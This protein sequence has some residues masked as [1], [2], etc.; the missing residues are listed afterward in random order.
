[1]VVIFYAIDLADKSVTSLTANLVVKPD[2][3]VSPDGAWLAFSATPTDADAAEAA[4]IYLA[5][6]D[7][8]WRPLVTG[9]DASAPAWRP[10][11]MPA[12]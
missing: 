10:E 5:S 4:G 12:G 9:V 11:V 2:L 7:G 8:G 6:R 3:A 1:M